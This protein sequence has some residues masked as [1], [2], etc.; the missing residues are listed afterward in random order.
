MNDLNTK[1]ELI[2]GFE[3]GADFLTAIISLCRLFRRFKEGG[4]PDKADAIKRSLLEVLN[5]E[6]LNA[7][8]AA[9]IDSEELINSDDELREAFTNYA[10][11]KH[12]EIELVDQ[13]KDDFFFEKQTIIKDPD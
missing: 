2:D 4:E 10:A 7:L 11:L 13:L 12:E 5:A 6:D 8:E 1:E 3:M 9:A